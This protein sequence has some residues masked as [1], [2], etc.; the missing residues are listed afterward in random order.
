MKSK[1]Y[2]CHTNTDFQV[3]TGERPP[4]TI[5]L[6]LDSETGKFEVGVSICSKQD[7][8]SRKK[9]REIA[10]VRLQGGFKE[11]DFPEV[12]TELPVQMACIK[13]LMSL[14]SSVV[15]HTNKWKKQIK[16]FHERQGRIVDWSMLE[17]SNL[18]KKLTPQNLT[19]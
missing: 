14:K 15:N 8:F 10:E 4:A 18:D 7:N 3:K 1:V 9:G 17:N 6:R 11:I 12:F 16:S 2:Y 13:M 5:A 19:D